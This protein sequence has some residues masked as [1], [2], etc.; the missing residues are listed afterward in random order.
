MN[1]LLWVNFIAFLAVTVYAISLF[2]Y[3]VKTRIE[4]YQ[5]R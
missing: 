3:V 4:L 1:G 5:T 2:I